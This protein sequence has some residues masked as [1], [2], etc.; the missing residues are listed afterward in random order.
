MSWMHDIT[1]I[2]NCNQKVKSISNRIPELMMVNIS[3]TYVFAYMYHMHTYI[4]IGF[5]KGLKGNK[6]DPW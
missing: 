4:A 5:N 3:Q 1:I 2:T 6:F